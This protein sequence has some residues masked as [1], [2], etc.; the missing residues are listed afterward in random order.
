M[1]SENL[2]VFYSRLFLKNE[3]WTFINVQKQKM[4]NNLPK[5]LL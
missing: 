1:C 3:K 5:N 2:K 4:E